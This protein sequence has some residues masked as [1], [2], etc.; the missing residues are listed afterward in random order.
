[1]S[2]Q[3][4]ILGN[5]PIFDAK[6]NIVRPQL[7]SMDEMQDGV[8]SI[9]ETGMVTKGRFLREF[10]EA[11]AAH[12]GVKHA[13]ALSS[14][15]TG[16]MLSYQGLGLI[17]DVVVPS[18]TFMASVSS[19]VWAGLRPVFADVD[20]GTTNLSPEA[21]EAAITPNTSAIVA[22]HNFGNPAEIEA[23]QAVADRHGLKL[24]F[25]AA[26][27]FGARYRGVPVGK[28]GDAHS[29]SLS[30]TKLLIAGEGGIVSTN[31]DALADH[32]RKGREYGNDGN[33][34]SAFAGINARMPEFNALLGLK[35]LQGLEGAAERRNATAA[36][37]RREMG[38]LP[39]IAFQKVHPEDRNSYREFS[40]L[41]DA[42]AFGVS[43]DH[44]AQALAAE[45]IDTRKYYDP[46]V[47]RQTA[48]RQFAPDESLLP[49]TI[50]LAENS[51]SFP[52][53]SNMEEETAL[54]ICA[55]VTR[56]HHHAEDVTKALNQ[57]RNASA[58]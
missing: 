29:F 27:G 49:N 26:H 15:T 42:E 54:K 1:M 36:I 16:L 53:W 22:V 14:C 3:P 30:P 10:E 44:L 58:V 28:Q 9:I 47:H 13:V 32:L 45:N 2:N 31:D 50:L 41:L 4:A 35:S 21:A 38:K 55:A 43:R 6:I 19:L 23:L 39:G 51:L 57:T 56:I 37:Y 25:D 17:G 34:D 8:R 52:M 46:P 48:Y 5:A 24:I 18:F 40:I 11:I 7:P 20:A 33:Y 12:L